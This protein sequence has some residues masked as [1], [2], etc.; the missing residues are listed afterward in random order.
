MI[1]LLICKIIMIV[2]FVVMPII[3]GKVMLIKDR[4]VF[5]VFAFIL[6]LFC[7][8]VGFTIILVIPV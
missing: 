5:S 7:C 4:D 3:I 2:F 6:L 8:V 1:F